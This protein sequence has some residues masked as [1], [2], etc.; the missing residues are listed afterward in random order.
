MARLHDETI[1][2]V[3][4]GLVTRLN[5][6]GVELDKVVGCLAAS[7]SRASRLAL[8]FASTES[9]LLCRDAGMQVCRDS[10]IQDFR[11]QSN[12]SG[13]WCGYSGFKAAFWKHEFVKSKVDRRDFIQELVFCRLGFAFFPVNRALRE[14]RSDCRPPA[15]RQVFPVTSVLAGKSPST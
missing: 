6:L 14:S 3:F 7:A 12:C 4:L 8:M 1:S 15:I 10:V 5:Q 2:G 9:A 11:I 13:C